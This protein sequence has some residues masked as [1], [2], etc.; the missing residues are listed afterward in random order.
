M[1]KRSLIIIIMLLFVATG[2]ASATQC[3]ENLPGWMKNAFCEQGGG[4]SGDA[5]GGGGRTGGDR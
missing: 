5:G 4:G 2:P 1:L 3:H